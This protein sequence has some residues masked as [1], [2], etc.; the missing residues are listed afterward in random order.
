MLFTQLHI[1]PKIQNKGNLKVQ[2]KDRAKGQ[3]HQIAPKSRQGAGILRGGR[4]ELQDWVL[5]KVGDAV[6]AVSYGDEG[7][8][9][10]EVPQNPD[11][12]HTKIK[13]LQ[14]LRAKRQ[15]HFQEKVKKLN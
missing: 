9:E 4:N 5:L 6:S 7:F 3:Y 11:F 2:S 1:W 8:I 12:R 14:R 13:D 15:A 10:E